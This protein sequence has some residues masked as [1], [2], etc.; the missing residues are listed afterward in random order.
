MI[1]A[2]L[3]QDAVPVAPTAAEAARIEAKYEPPRWGGQTAEP[4]PRYLRTYW[5]AAADPDLI[6]AQYVSFGAARGIRL[7]GSAQDVRLVADGG[8]GVVNIRY[9]VSSGALS[10]RCGGR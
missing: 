10:A 6:E 3:A 9:R 7:L 2:I 8:C 5:R 1:A 4:L